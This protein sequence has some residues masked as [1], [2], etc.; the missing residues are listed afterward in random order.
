MIN[1]YFQQ[2]QLHFLSSMPA[3]LTYPDHHLGDFS[4]LLAEL[5]QREPVSEI[6]IAKFQTIGI[7]IAL[8]ATWL[9][10]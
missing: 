9:L 6:Y 8:H 5:A 2:M 4:C 7:S 1:L 3:P 10:T